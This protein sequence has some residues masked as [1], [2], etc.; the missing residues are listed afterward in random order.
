MR[1]PRASRTLRTRIPVQGDALDTLT[2][3]VAVSPQPTHDLRTQLQQPLTQRP[4]P[5]HDQ[6]L[7]I[8][9]G[10]IVAIA[11]EDQIIFQ[12]KVAQNGG[13]EEA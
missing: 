9:K 1:M 12:V 4:N 2:A 5:E 6:N 10:Q 8:S 13:R 7:Q 3:P 11:N